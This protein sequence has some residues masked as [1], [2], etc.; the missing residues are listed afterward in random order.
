MV[1]KKY[2]FHSYNVKKSAKDVEL[3][4]LNEQIKCMR[5]KLRKLKRIAAE[6]AVKLSAVI[7]IQTQNEE[8]E[9]DV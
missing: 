8:K 3:K 1:R 9:N 5:K 7:E 4:A 6:G 2:F